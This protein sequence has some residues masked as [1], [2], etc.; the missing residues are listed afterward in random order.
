MKRDDF[1]TKFFN[2]N[3]SITK[4]YRN[5]FSSSIHKNNAI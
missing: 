3:N 2:T 1:K 4:Y 5:K